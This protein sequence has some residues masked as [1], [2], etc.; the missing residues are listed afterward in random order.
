MFWYLQKPG[1]AIQF[2]LQDITK[3]KDLKEEFKGRI[4]YQHDKTNKQFPMNIT[5]AKITDSG[6]YYCVMSPTV[7]NQHKEM[8]SYMSSCCPVLEKFNA[9]RWQQFIAMIVFM[10]LF[11]LTYH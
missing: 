11:F 6:T 8:Y 5:S 4:D 9:I 1:Q 2:L 7:F 3:K 10:Q